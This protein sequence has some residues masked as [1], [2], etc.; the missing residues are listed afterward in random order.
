MGFLDVDGLRRVVNNLSSKIDQKLATAGG[1]ITGDLA[2]NGVLTNGGKTMAQIADE[3][4][5]AQGETLHQW[6]TEPKLV[7]YF[8]GKPVYEKSYVGSIGVNS[9]NQY[10]FSV[11]LDSNPGSKVF[12][13]VR[14]NVG[15]INI[16]SMMLSMDA[17]S[18]TPGVQIVAFTKI[19]TDGL[20][21]SGRS[22]VGQSYGFSI[23]YF[24]TVTYFDNT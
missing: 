2:V 24:V 22:P 11:V 19:S 17:S 3:R 14:G 8:N 12:I 20:T 15:G 6:S 10:K 4:I 23:N 18:T 9:S 13:N 7:G 21:L 1:T 16:G 5:A